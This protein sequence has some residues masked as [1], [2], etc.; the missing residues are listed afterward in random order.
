MKRWL[1]MLLAALGV[2]GIA[3]AQTSVPAG[4]VLLVEVKGAIGIATTLHVEAALQQAAAE[5]ASLVVL[6]LDTPGGLV[7]ATRDLIQV[8]LAAQVPIAVYIAPSGARAASAGTY[9]AYAA[10]IAAMAPGTHLGAATP[11]QLGGVPG[12]P[13]PQR[14]GTDDKARD[15]TSAAERKMVNDAVAYIRSLAQLRGRNAEW[16]EK[17]VREAATL[18]AEDALAEKVVDLVAPDLAALL[19]QL[20]G[21]TVTLGGTQQRLATKDR[22]IAS[23]TPNWRTRL[24]AAIAD[25][26]VALILLMLGFYGVLFEFMHPGA[27]AP[28]VIGGI[29][30]L[31]GFAALSVLPVSWAGLGLLLL[32][33]A[34]MTGEAFTPGVGVLG[35]GGLLAFVLGALFLFDPG[36]ADIE[37][38]VAWP[39]VAITGA[40]TAGFLALVMG[41]ALRARRRAVTSGSEQMIGIEGRVV[42]WQGTA[43]SVRV[44]GEV[45]GARSEG[46]FVPGDAV[47]VVKREGLMLSV[48]AA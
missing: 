37:I 18:T 15:A 7:S 41:F 36:G 38:S 22:E 1:I 31:L 16:A 23:V 5:R 20:D 39:V 24:I 30:L 33:L 17:A 34:L 3:A 35:I 40:L 12:S 29:S 28:G 42:D 9:I 14:R 44:H 32:G 25:P 46:T 4:R 45:W 26:N 13:E 8:I 21:R 47:R 48:R 11:I 6:R 43:G 27:A 10:P 19:A 2:C